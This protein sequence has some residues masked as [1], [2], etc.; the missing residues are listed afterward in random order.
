MKTEYSNILGSL[1]EQSQERELNDHI[2]ILDGMNTFIRNF[3]FIKTINPQGF[4]IGGLLGFLKSLGLLVRII[5]PTRVIVVWDGK[6]GST[7]RKYI[8]PSYKAHRQHSRVIHWDIYDSKELE[9]Q[10]MT[11][12]KERL[13]DYLDCLPLQTVT[14]DKLE[15]DDIIAYLAKK[16]SAAGKQVTIVSSDK[17]FYQLINNNIS[18]YSPIRKMLFTSKNIKE[19]IGVLA[20]NY[21]IIKALLGDSSDGIQGVKGL[22]IKTILSE[23]S[24]VETNPEVELSYIFRVCEEKLQKKKIFATIVNEW[25]R[26]ER[27]FKIMNLHETVLDTREKEMLFDVLRYSPPKLRTGVFLHLLKQDGIEGITK[28]T[29]GWLQTFASLAVY[30]KSE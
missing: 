30:A 2:L 27:N 26:V 21:N 25:D 22:G 24:Q 1:D 10:S 4:H 11:D 17:D 14:I 29:E 19:E 23:F 8:D 13:Q 28:N 7:N 16:A 5:D 9:M 20:E 15:A 12:Q 18:V 6:G 3:S